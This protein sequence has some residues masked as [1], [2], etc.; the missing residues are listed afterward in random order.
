[1]TTIGNTE[2]DILQSARVLIKHMGYEVAEV[3]AQDRARHLLSEG[4]SAGHDLW[5]KIAIA[6]DW[7]HF[8]AVGAWLG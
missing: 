5:R 2:L 1:M 7:L 3:L 6:I 4:D 8:M